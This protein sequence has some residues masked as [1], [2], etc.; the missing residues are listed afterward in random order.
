MAVEITYTALRKGLAGYLDRVTD[1]HEAVIIRRRG[2][3]DVAII[4][5]DELSSL[6]ETVHLLRSPTNAERLTQAVR[7]VER[8]GGEVMTAEELRHSI[9]L[10]K[11]RWSNL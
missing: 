2:A 7:E 3:R 5:A 6:L 9:A 10:D 8:G 4:R 1:D 11:K